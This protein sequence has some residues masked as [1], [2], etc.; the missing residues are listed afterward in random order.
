MVE[1]GSGFL[2]TAE[3]FRR[4]DLIWGMDVSSIKG[5]TKKQTTASADN[6]LVSKSTQRM[7]VLSIDIMYLEKIPILIGVATSTY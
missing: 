3:D 6:S 5:K 2:V 7:Q 4:A 1:S